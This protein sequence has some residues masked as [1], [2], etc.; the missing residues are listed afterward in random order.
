MK[1]QTFS[2]VVGGNKCNACCP[3]CVSKMTGKLECSTSIDDI[4]WRNFN[5]ACQFAKM[6]GV[7]TVLLTGKGEPTLYPD[8]ITAYLRHLQQY[9]F[10]F[11]E[12]QTNGIE[13]EKLSK[14]LKGFPKLPTYLKKW[15]DLGLTTV[16]LSCVHWDDD[17]NKKIFGEKYVGLKKNINLLHENK[18]SVRTSCVMAKEYIGDVDQVVEFLNK[19]YDW[20]NQKVLAEQMTFRPVVYSGHVNTMLE[21]W[22]SCRDWV[23]EHSISQK[24]EKEIAKYFD[25]NSRLLLN[26]AHGAKV[27][28][29]EGQNISINNCLTSSTDPDDIRQL[30]FH[31]DGHLYYDWSSKAAIII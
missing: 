11:I 23:S 20:D 31:P 12:L 29:H 16:S 9:C 17:K 18:F 6:S 21:E 1:I 24:K 13:L 14:P 5:K 8:H 27:Y 2:I 26:L 10:P 30:I 25:D 7:S 15:Y 19:I 4:N 3:Y 28:D 22:L